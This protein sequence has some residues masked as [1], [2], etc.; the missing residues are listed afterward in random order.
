M[1]ILNQISVKYDNRYR[2]RIDA[3]DNFNYRPVMKKVAK[4]FDVHKRYVEE[5]IENLKRYY[6]VALLDAKNPHAVS[7]AVDPFWHT[8]VLFSREYVKFCNDVFGAYVHHIPLDHD[9]A[10]EVKKV[11]LIYDYTIAKHKEI[12]HDVDDAWWPLSSAPGALICYQPEALICYQPDL[13]QYTVK[14][15]YPVVKRLQKA[16][17]V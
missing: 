12:F 17:R 6:I 5:G 7:R 3:I 1:S 2:K 13:M 15:V 8:H 4:D 10:K 9:D 11:R 14:G 16:V